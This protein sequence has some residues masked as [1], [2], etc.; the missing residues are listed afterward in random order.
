MTPGNPIQFH[1]NPANS[2]V[3]DPQ[4]ASH[5]RRV[6]NPKVL[7]EGRSTTLTER[8]RHGRHMATPYSKRAVCHRCDARGLCT[9]GGMEVGDDSP[10][11]NLP[12]FSR[13]CLGMHGFAT[14]FGREQ[15]LPDLARTDARALPVRGSGSAAAPSETSASSRPLA[16]R[17]QASRRGL[18]TGPSEVKAAPLPASVLVWVF[19]TDGAAVAACVRKGSRAT[20]AATTP[21]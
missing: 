17:V 3:S 1:E 9:S 16:R 19:V 2:Q 14:A 6:R 11:R 10:G 18:A 15:K 5:N 12:W 4:K 7:G 8:Q 21:A 13:A 20:V